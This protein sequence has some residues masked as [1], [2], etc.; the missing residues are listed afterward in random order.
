MWLYLPDSITS[1]CVPASGLSTWLSEPLCQGLA[2]HATWRTESKPPRFWRRAFKTSPWMRRLFGPTLQ[3]SQQECSE[4]VATWLS[5]AFPV[6]PTVSPVSSLVTKTNEHSGPRQSESSTSSDPPWSSSRTSQGCF[7]FGENPERNYRDWVIG[8]RRDSLARRKSAHRIEESGSLSWPSPQS[9]LVNDGE[10]IESWE[11]RRQQNLGKKINGNGMGTPLTIASQVWQTP[12]TD[13][14]RSRGGDRVEERGLDQQARFWTTPTAHDGRRETDNSSQQHANLKTDAEK[15]PTPISSEAEA[16]ASG[17]RLCLTDKVSTWPTPQGRDHRSGEASEETANKNSRP[18]NEAATSWPSPRV[19]RGAYTRDHGNPETERPTLEGKAEN[20]QTPSAS[21]HGHTV[22]G[23][24]RRTEEL[25]A[26]QAK[27]FSHQ[28]RE[29]E[30]AGKKSSSENP[31]LRRRLNPNFDGLAD[32]AHEAIGDDDDDDDDEM[33]GTE[34]STATDQSGEMSGVRCDR[35]EAG[36]TPQGLQQAAGSRD[37]LSA[38]SPKGRPKR[39]HG[40]ERRTRNMQ[41]VRDGISATSQQARFALWFTELQSRLREIVSGQAMGR[42]EADRILRELWTRV[43]AQEA[44]RHDLRAL[45]RERASVEVETSE[46][47][48]DRLRACGNGVV[49]LTAAWAFICLA[50]ELEI[51]FQEGTMI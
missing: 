13:S 37:S 10:S 12:A 39:W 31:G 30:N 38:V 50:Q 18:L 3:R 23:G 40:E 48:L 32:R 29:S 21:E 27:S 19:S 6:S 28:D 22:R 1:A 41:S 9:N 34:T 46:G 8:L 43:S 49:P 11:A 42:E 25:L 44:E 45:L 51:E 33:G 4:A 24:D 5:R 26:G 20:W 14:V 15:W 36:A 35:R 47:R 17:N 2:Q 7:A 16:Q